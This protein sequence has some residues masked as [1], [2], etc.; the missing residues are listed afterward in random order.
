MS[1]LATTTTK[2]R[3]V[4][5]DLSTDL[6]AGIEVL[7]AEVTLTRTAWMRRILNGAVRLRPNSEELAAGHPNRLVLIFFR[8]GSPPSQSW[9]PKPTAAADPHLHSYSKEENHGY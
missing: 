4:Q 3:P 5:I 9:K 8:L 7:A 1:D 6:I 2:K